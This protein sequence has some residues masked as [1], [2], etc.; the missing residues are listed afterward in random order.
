M[1]LAETAEFCPLMASTDDLGVQAARRSGGADA[2]EDDRKPLA[3]C[4]RPL[5]RRISAGAD[6]VS[7]VPGRRPRAGLPR[8]RVVAGPIRL[9]DM[10]EAMGLDHSPINLR[11]SALILRGNSVLLC[12]RPHL[13][14]WV[15]PG[16]ALKRSETVAACAVREVREETGLRVQVLGVAFVLDTVSTAV[17]GQL[18][19]IVFHAR[20]L[21][22]GPDEPAVVE[23]GRI[24]LFV[25]LDTLDHVNVRPRID[26]A[27]RQFARQGG[28]TVAYLGNLWRYKDSTASTE[29]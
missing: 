22:D 7:T 26:G 8:A 9:R 24:P 16:G 13:T 10:E 19:E 15:L 27:I 28:P 5:S 12:Q 2:S 14:D 23:E 6:P 17:G 11:C 3:A 1:G 4:S 25:P 18:A 29:W 20:Q 21:D